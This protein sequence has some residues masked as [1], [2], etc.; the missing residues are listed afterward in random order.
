MQLP[1]KPSIIVFIAIVVLAVLTAVIFRDNL[2][3]ENFE[4]KKAT[5][6]WYKADWCGHC[7]RMKND[8]AEV[9]AKVDKSKVDVKV[10]KDTD[11][12]ADKILQEKGVQGFPTIHLEKDGKTIPYEGPRTSKDILAFV[13]KQLKA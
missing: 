2:R 4:Q 13:D 10:V 11:K 8:W 12:G 3:V 6:V 7:N 1:L 5:L 9:E